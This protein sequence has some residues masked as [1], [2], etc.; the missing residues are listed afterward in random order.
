VIKGYDREK[1]YGKGFCQFEAVHGELDRHGVPDDSE[2]RAKVVR[3]KREI[4]DEET[5][6]AAMPSSNGTHAAPSL[7][8]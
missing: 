3:S 8:A 5:V 2:L 4:L 6:R 7:D 1:C